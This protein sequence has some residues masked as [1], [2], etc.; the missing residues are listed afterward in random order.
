M[1]VVGRL[2]LRAVDW[3]LGAVDIQDQV[4]PERAGHLVLHQVR[5]EARESLIVPILREDFGFEP[6]QG[7]RQ[8]DARLP[9]L[10]RGQHPKRRV[11]GQPLGAVGVLVPRQAAIERLANEIRQGELGVAAGAGIAEVSFDQHA[12]AEVLVQLAGQ[13]E[14]G[15]RGHRRAAEF[16]AKLGIEREANRVRFRVTHWVVPSIPARRP[17]EPR[18]MQA[19]SDYR[20]ARSPFKSKMRVQ[21][22]AAAASWKGSS[23]ASRPFFVTRMATGREK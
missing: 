19:L 13:Q 15:V 7:G 16:D 17:R 12:Q 10:R 23:P 3:P 11:L 2:L 20:P 1:A 8:C 14:P 4:P 22:P 9:A 5:V 21:M 18:F 6:V